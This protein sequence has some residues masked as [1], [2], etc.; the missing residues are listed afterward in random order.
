MGIDTVFQDMGY[1]ATSQFA[2]NERDYF[3]RFVEFR[4]EQFYSCLPLLA[5]LFVDA[6][7][8][9]H[10]TILQHESNVNTVDGIVAIE[11]KNYSIHPFP[12]MMH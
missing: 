1:L 10:D 4:N 6:W 12:L 2:T 11:V 8:E 7:R 5:E 9:A 3:L